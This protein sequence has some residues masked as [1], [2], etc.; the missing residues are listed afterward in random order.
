MPRVRITKVPLNW[1][2]SWLVILFMIPTSFATTV[3]SI[4]QIPNN[5]FI[6]L[7]VLS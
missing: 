3:F 1:R 5:I 7:N 4:F 6:L 2:S